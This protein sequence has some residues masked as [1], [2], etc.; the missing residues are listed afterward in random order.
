MTLVCEY[1]IITHMYT[2]TLSMDQDD[3]YFKVDVR[4]WR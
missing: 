3:D 1:F 2:H 4:S